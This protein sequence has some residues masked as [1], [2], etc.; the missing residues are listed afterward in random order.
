MTDVIDGPP[1]ANAHAAQ[2]DD[3][4]S[5]SIMTVGNSE[6]DRAGWILD[7]LLSA[8]DQADP[9][10]GSARRALQEPA[11]DATLLFR[12]PARAS[13]RLGS[14]APVTPAPVTP[15]PFTAAEAP[16][17]IDQ[18]QPM[19]ISMLRVVARGLA[20]A[21]PQGPVLP[22]P[23]DDGEK[24]RYVR[25]HAWLLTLFSVA[26][27]PL[28]LFSQVRLM[29]QYHWFWVYS[30]CV[31]LAALFLALPLLTDGLSRSF[32]FDEHRR[33]VDNCWALSAAISTAK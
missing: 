21:K 9:A 26:S 7:E 29:L 14:P 1:G 5:F 18:T 27:F 30:P 20:P 31:V 11:Q 25:H 28:L 13:R 33:L 32:D 15:A 4:E 24:F 6:V 22:V 17:D 12:R 16:Q 3:G 10:T 19:P 8:E 23:P 2:K